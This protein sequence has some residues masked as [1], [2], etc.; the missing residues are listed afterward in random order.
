MVLHVGFS[1]IFSKINEATDFI[2]SQRF[3][4]VPINVN[5]EFLFYQ[6]DVTGDIEAYS[7]T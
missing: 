4:H 6:L 1:I 3:F 7:C 2:F 5:A